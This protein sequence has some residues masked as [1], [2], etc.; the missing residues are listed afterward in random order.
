[1]ILILYKKRNDLK[2]ELAGVTNPAYFYYNFPPTS[3]LVMPSGQ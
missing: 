2:C 3:I 1:M